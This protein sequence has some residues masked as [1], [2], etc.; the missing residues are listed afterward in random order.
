MTAYANGHPI[1]DIDALVQWMGYEDEDEMHN[2]HE[3]IHELLCEGLGI[4]SYARAIQ[5][6]EDVGEVGEYLALLEEAAV[7]HA[8]RLL[9]IYWMNH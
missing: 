5:D 3:T 7:I 8:Q 2:D 9:Q 4:K 1:E 6:G